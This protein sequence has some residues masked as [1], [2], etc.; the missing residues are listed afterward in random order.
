M[1]NRL[2]ALE[3]ENE[4]LRKDKQL[5]SQQ[6]WNCPGGDADPNG[7]PTE[8]QQA[9]GRCTGL[10]LE[11][12]RLR[13]D[14][15]QFVSK[16][17]PH[18]QAPFYV[19]ASSTIGIPSTSS[20]AADHTLSVLPPQ[21]SP[22]SRSS[23]GMPL[24]S[25][26]MVGAG[27]PSHAISTP[28]QPTMSLSV[29]AT[30]SSVSTTSPSEAGAH[31]PSSTNNTTTSFDAQSIWE[32]SVRSNGGDPSACCSGFFRCDVNGQVIVPSPTEL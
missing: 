26:S 14:A 29:A 32:Q 27:M 20:A 4:Q 23:S 6:V 9:C 19:A 22:S 28:S 25:S 31:R 21:P 2:T 5:L 1:K 13:D 8:Q 7:F 24:S 17:G 16:M 30:P 10:Q 11:I 12:D 15:R 3:T 18:V